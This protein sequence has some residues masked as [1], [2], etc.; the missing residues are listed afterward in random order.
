MKHLA[1]LIYLIL[2]APLT[3]GGKMFNPFRLSA[4][5]SPCIFNLNFN[6]VGECLK[7]FRLSRNRFC[8]KFKFVF[9]LSLGQGWSQHWCEQ[10]RISPLP[11]CQ[12]V[13]TNTAN[14][15]PLCS[16]TVKMAAKVHFGCH[17]GSNIKMEVLIKSSHERHLCFC[18]MKVFAAFLPEG[19][20]G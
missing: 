11:I 8:I 16:F 17:S 13:C 14:M 3:M 15:S 9:L 2:G 4:I 7:Y 5:P 19:K 6:L 12:A 10:I 20:K 18:Q 1:I